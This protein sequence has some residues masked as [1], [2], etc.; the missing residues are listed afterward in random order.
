[1]V[2]WLGYDFLNASASAKILNIATNVAA[3]ILFTAKGHVWWHFAVPLAAA[4][5]LGSMLGTWMAL[6]KGSGF[7]RGM[8]IVVVAALILKTG[9]DAFL[10]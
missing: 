7:V 3:L 5:I 6:K 2:R 1:M 8:F 9:Y 4:N 10:R